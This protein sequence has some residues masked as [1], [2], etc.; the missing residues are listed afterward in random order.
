M[1]RISR[2]SMQF[3]S[4]ETRKSS[5][6][7]HPL[8]NDNT[9]VFGSTLQTLN[10]YVSRFPNI[11]PWDST[12]LNVISNEPEPS[13]FTRFNSGKQIINEKQQHQGSE[14]IIE[15]PGSTI[16]QNASHQNTL[17]PFFKIQ[18]DIEKNEKLHQSYLNKSKNEQF[19]LTNTI[20]KTFNDQEVPNLTKKSEDTFAYLMKE[21]NFQ[22]TTT[23][24]P[25]TPNQVINND[26]HIHKNCYFNQQTTD[27]YRRRQKHRHHHHQFNQPNFIE[28]HY[29]QYRHK[30]REF[31]KPIDNHIYKDNR[32]LRPA[33]DQR[34][35]YQQQIHPFNNTNNENINRKRKM[36]TT[37]KENENCKRDRKAK[38]KFDVNLQEQEIN[39]KNDN[40]RKGKFVTFKS[41]LEL[42][43]MSEDY[44]THHKQV[45][46]NHFNRTIKHRRNHMHFMTSTTTHT[47]KSTTT[48]RQFKDSHDNHRNHHHHHHQR[49]NKYHHLINRDTHEIMRQLFDKSTPHQHQHHQKYFY[50]MQNKNFIRHPRNF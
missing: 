45:E 11:V 22:T 48:T 21:N 28:Q 27:H 37:T 50:L 41:E 14:P 20:K 31:L 10:K 30:K 34:L 15:T 39:N 44:E 26:T 43:E 1:V 49:A 25:Y 18:E 12:I 19:S 9:T 33:Y 47:A 24:S 17:D 4:S 23:K 16:S 2:S 35:H 29:Q 7:Y 5:Y 36:E 13:L 8:T 46:E 42:R 3:T 38:V 40:G 6:N 32:P